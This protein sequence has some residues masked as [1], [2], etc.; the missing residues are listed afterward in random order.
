[1]AQPLGVPT[2]LSEDLDLVLIPSFLNGL[3]TVNCNSSTRRSSILF[4]PLRASALICACP[5]IDIHIYTG[6][7][8]NIQRSHCVALA[9]L[10]LRE[11]QLI[12]FATYGL[13][14]NIY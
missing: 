2:A 6:L 10:E 9:D 11:I 14:L 5:H 4:W 1:M 8:K 13:G 3:L 7:K 12:A